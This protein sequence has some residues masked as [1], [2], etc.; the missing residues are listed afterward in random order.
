MSNNSINKLKIK[1]PKFK[2]ADE[3][4]LI[5]YKAEIEAYLLSIAENQ[6]FVTFDQIKAD[7]LAMNLTGITEQDIT[8]QKLIK[9]CES[10][11]IEYLPE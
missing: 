7:I 9:I 3:L 10:Y 8:D 2:N 6:E 11:L 1:N 5:R 4:R